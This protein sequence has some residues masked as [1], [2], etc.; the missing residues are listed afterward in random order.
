MGITDR[1]T[2]RQKPTGGQTDGHTNL[3]DKK[4][5]KTD[6]REVGH[7]RE[8][9]TFETKPEIDLSLTFETGHRE[10]K[11]HKG[12]IPGNSRRMQSYNLN[13]SRLRKRTANSSDLLAEGTLW[14]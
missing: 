7:R 6:E 5:G 4:T 2:L 14:D 13:Y 9:R 11:S 8:N 3:T 10:L 1:M 12:R